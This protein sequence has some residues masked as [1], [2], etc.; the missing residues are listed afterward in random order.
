MRIEEENTN[1]NT[2]RILYCDKCPKNFLTRGGIL[3]HLEFPQRRGIKLETDV[4]CPYHPKSFSNMKKLNGHLRGNMC[5][6]TQ[7]NWLQVRG[8]IAKN[9]NIAEYH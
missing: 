4:L 9:C 2:P 1:E 3:N 7:N 8:E 5:K 6:K